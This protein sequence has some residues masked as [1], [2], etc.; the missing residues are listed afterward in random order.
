MLYVMYMY[1]LCMLCMLYVKY[2]Y[3]FCPHLFCGMLHM[4]GV[5]ILCHV[6][7]SRVVYICVHLLCTHVPPVLFT[8]M[9]VCMVCAYKCCVCMCVCWYVVYVDTA[10]HRVPFGL[11]GSVPHVDR[12]PGP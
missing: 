9:H 11:V 10:Q 1:L 6:C 4:C 5:Y 7:V 3:V 8:C 2:M 12:V